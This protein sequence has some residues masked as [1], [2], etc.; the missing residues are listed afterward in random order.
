MNFP[1]P[2]ECLWGGRKS[3]FKCLLWYIAHYLSIFSLL[4]DIYIRTFPQG[5]AKEVK[6]FPCSSSHKMEKNCNFFSDVCSNVIFLLS[7][8]PTQSLA[9]S[10]FW[11]GLPVI[12]SCWLCQFKNPHVGVSISS[13]NCPS[14]QWRSLS[15]D[16]HLRSAGYS[17][18]HTQKKERRWKGC[19]CWVPLESSSIL[20]S[21]G[22][23]R[24]NN[25]HCFSNKINL[26][27]LD[28]CSELMRRR[29]R[30]FCD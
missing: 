14:D 22:K 20:G 18:T 2:K 4:L 15:A 12:L 29:R 11:N 26:K 13:V 28:Y 9:F 6:Y 27:L 5:V 1:A 16:L 30:I 7:C 25:L 10:H 23:G 17:T 21:C 24:L 8:I 19:Y 3:P